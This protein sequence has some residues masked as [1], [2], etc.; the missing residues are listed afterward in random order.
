MSQVDVPAGRLRFG[1]TARKD[2][3]WVSPILNLLGIVIGFGYLTW[4]LLQSKYYWAPPY[5]TPLASPL[6]FGDSPHAWF[7]HSPPTWWPSALPFMPGLFILWIPAP[8][9]ATCYYYRGSY[10]KAL[11][12]DP[13][14]C[15]VGEP[16]HGYRGE[17]SFPLIL[18]NV[19]RF[20]MYGALLFI[21]LLTWDVLMATRFPVTPGLEKP[22][23]FGIGLG[24]L[25]MAVNLV[26][27]ALYTFSCHSFRH[28]VGGVLDVM[29]G[30][31][32][33]KKIYDCASCL[34]RQ[35]MLWAWL[36]LFT[37]CV[38]DA[39]IRLCAAGVIHDWRIV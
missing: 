1:Q 9:R 4:G 17:N 29:T 38:T 30:S 10:Y 32:T 8:F 27:I 14:G 37:M 26:A 19:H 28:L 7:S 15:S 31:P 33:R 12:A 11:L 39:Y 23:T 2:A 20:F 3:W 35:H 16:R 5:L 21:P 25:I 34:N 36:S 22:T 18:Q 13:P 6:L 24:T